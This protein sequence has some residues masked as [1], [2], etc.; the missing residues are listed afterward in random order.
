MCDSSSQRD[1][2][3]TLT[4]LPSSCWTWKCSGTFA[5][6]RKISGE[7]SWIL[8]TT[9]LTWGV[10]GF[11]CA[12]LVAR[13]RVSFKHL[14][15]LWEKNPLQLECA[16][17]SAP[18]A[19]PSGASGGDTGFWHLPSARQPLCLGLP[20][21][22]CWHDV[23][24]WRHHVSGLY[25]QHRGGWCRGELIMFFPVE[26]G[27]GMATGHRSSEIQRDSVYLGY[28]PILDPPQVWIRS[29]VARWTEPLKSCASRSNTHFTIG[30]HVRYWVKL[31]SSALNVTKS[32]TGSSW[33]LTTETLVAT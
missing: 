33:G 1:T 16:F 12:S 13:G 14:S 19:F 22:W 17:P 30:P 21:H 10:T 11:S 7:S 32:L 8:P 26:V 2:S 9:P 15:R 18:F 4:N 5:R 3:A 31:A 24:C 27:R 25:S 20:N 28:P 23:L 6:K 29:E